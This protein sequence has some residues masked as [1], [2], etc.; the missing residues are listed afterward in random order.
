M[1]KI[2]I[3]REVWS[4]LWC[5]DDTPTLVTSAILKTLVKS[6]CTNLLHAQEHLNLD[7][8]PMFEGLLNSLLE[9]STQHEHSHQ[10]SSNVLVNLQY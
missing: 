1:R 5:E 7:K 4:W 9:L 6:V 8:C 2:I 3:Q 10:S